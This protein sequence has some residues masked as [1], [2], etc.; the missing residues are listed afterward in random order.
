MYAC[1]VYARKKQFYKNITI[2]NGHFPIFFFFFGKIAI[3]LYEFD[4]KEKKFKKTAGF[5]YLKSLA[6]AKV[7]NY[8]CLTDGKWFKFWQQYIIGH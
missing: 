8:I 3:L 7:Q 2:Y 5:I 4:W 1:Q 6:R